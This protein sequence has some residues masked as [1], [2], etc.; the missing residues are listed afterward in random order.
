MTGLAAAPGPPRPAE[1]LGGLDSLRGVAA[2]LVVVMHATHIARGDPAA[3]LAF[4]GFWQ[5]G[6]AGVDFFFVLSGF[7]ITY[8]H[9]RDVGRPAAFGA[10]WMKRALRIYPPYWIVTAI[11][12]AILVVSPTK[13]MAE[14]D[15]IHILCSLLLLPEPAS[16]ILDV[17]WSLRHELV[18]YA[19]FGVA[20]LNRRAGIAVLALWG[21]AVL[22]NMAV[23]LATGAPFFGAALGSVALRGFNVEFFFG[24]AAAILV[25]RG[26]V[27]RPGL[28]ALAGAAAFLAVGMAE[29]FGPAIMPEWP[30]RSLAYGLAAG[31]TVYGVATL[32]RA[33]RSR[34]PAIGL[35][36]G[37][38]SYSIYLIHVPVLMVLQFL[39]R[40]VA[41][42]A[43][44]P[45][46][47]TVGAFAL[48]AIAVGTL[49]SEIVEQPLLRYGNRR[50]GPRRVRAE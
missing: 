47:L 22:G 26:R 6:R 36:F 10:F 17:G 34:A 37:R 49:F 14:R 7:V 8:V 35:L 38:A 42:A 45:A 32:D 12:G 13:E 44:L 40:H 33:G 46:E 18:F 3:P 25:R 2:I 9:F 21:M 5:F 11:L 1:R 23:Q 15:P 31:L 24:I 27:W 43:A 16:P 50:F 41:Q 4:G 30:I 48:A 19:L 28:C 39:I 29:S 20:V